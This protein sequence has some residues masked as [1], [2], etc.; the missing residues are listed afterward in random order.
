M[1]AMAAG[2]AVVATDIP[3]NR[4]LIAHDKTGFLVPVGDCAALARHAF[5]VLEDPNSRADLREAARREMLDNYPVMNMV[6]QHAVLY[7]ELIAA[8]N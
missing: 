5:Q 7:R 2:V 4:D 8:A 1:E 6:D 3:G